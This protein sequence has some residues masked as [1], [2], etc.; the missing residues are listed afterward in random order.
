MDGYIAKVLAHSAQ[1][2]PLYQHLSTH[3]L[4][5]HLVCISCINSIHH[6]PKEISNCTS[7]FAILASIST[8][9]V[10]YRHYIICARIVLGESWKESRSRLLMLSKTAFD[11][12][13]VEPHV[14]DQEASQGGEL[15]Y[16]LPQ[17]LGHCALSFPGKTH[18]QTP[19]YIH[20][21][22]AAILA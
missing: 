20:V 10:N 6:V 9:V 5:C 12:E 1:R 7:G 19:S 18:S 2:T 3:S 15:H 13:N 8:H 14:D 17:F 11:N 21:L 16:D 22:L 4:A